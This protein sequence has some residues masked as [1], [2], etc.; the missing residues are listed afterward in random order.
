MQRVG[1][2]YVACA[3]SRAA[4]TG[5]FGGHQFA[6]AGAT[7]LVQIEKRQRTPRANLASTDAS[8]RS[9]PGAALHRG[10]V[11]DNENGTAVHRAEAVNLAIAAHRALR[12]GEILAVDHPSD[13][14]EG[15]GIE[16]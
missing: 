9:T 11:G 14:E 13:G 2:E 4:G 6:D 3:H 16:Q 15:A 10:V 5:K 12:I 1:S 7:T 8:V